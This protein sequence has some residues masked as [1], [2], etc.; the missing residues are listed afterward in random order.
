MWQQGYRGVGGDASWW[1]PARGLPFQS[2]DIWSADGESTFCI[3]R[4]NRA[5]QDGPISQDAE[6]KGFAWAPYQLV[7]L[8]RQVG[9]GDVACG[10]HGLLCGDG[11]NQSV[12]TNSIV[13]IVSS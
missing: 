12:S 1:R 7:Q 3:E 6:E 9:L 8:S 2:G 13:S 10:V 5:V 4:G 11:V